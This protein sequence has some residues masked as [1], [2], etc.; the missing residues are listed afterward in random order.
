M[1]NSFEHESML[2]SLEFIVKNFSK[3]VA[4]FAP[5]LISHLVG[6]FSSLCKSTQQT[7]DED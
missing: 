3:E 6:L 1:L 2:G 4:K 7:E 5:Q